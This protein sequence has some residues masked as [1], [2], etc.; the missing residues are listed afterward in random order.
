MS[1]RTIEFTVSA[2]GSV[3]PVT[4]QKAGIQGEHNKTELVISVFR[5]ENLTTS[6]FLKDVI[7]IQFIDGAGGFYSTEILNKDEEGNVRCTIPDEVTNAGGLVCAYVVLTQL[8]DTGSG[9]VRVKNVSISKPCKLRFEHSGVGSPSEYAYRVNISGALLNAQQ[10]AEAAENYADNSLNY[11]NLAKDYSNAAKTAQSNAEAAANQASSNA[12][13]AEAKANEATTAK[14]NAERSA[15]IAGA[16]EENANKH[17]MAVK[18]AV[19]AEQKRIDNISANAIKGTVSGSEILLTDVSPIVHDMKVRVSSDSIS[20][21]STVKLIKS[22]GSGETIAEY[23]PTADGTVD[24]VTSRGAKQKNKSDIW[25]GSVSTGLQGT[26]SKDDPFLINSAADFAYFATSSHAKQYTKLMSDIY[27]NDVSDPEWYKGENLNTWT[28]GKAPGNFDGNGYVV[29]GIYINEPDSEGAGLFGNIADIAPQTISNL[30]IE[31]S[32]ISVSTSSGYATALFYMANWGA[33]LLV[34]NCYVSDTVILKGYNAGGLAGYLGVTTTFIN[35]YAS[36]KIIANYLAGALVSFGSYHD[37]Y[38]QCYSSQN[39]PFVRYGANNST[40]TNCYAVNNT[41]CSNVSRL[42][43]EQMTGKAAYDNMAGLDFRTVWYVNEYGLPRLRAF[44][45][46]AIE[47]TTDTEGVKIYC[48]YNKNTN[49]CLENTFN[50]IA[51][52]KNYADSTFA[53][54]AALKTLKSIVDGKKVTYRDVAQNQKLII[55]KSKVYIFKAYSIDNAKINLWVTDSSGTEAQAYDD[56]D[57]LFPNCTAGILICPADTYNYS[58]V[59]LVGIT[60]KLSITNL[61]PFYGKGLANWRHSSI[62]NL[63]LKL[64]AGNGMGVW[65]IA[66]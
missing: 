53:T 21:L 57:E 2:D 60:G 32:Y 36:A 39:L 31:D 6:I 23:T 59:L 17:R 65:T 24:S 28:P 64:T 43:T 61:S 22:N 14:E 47:L 4:E 45:Y 10:S 25:D 18:E 1:L 19:A 55:E 16:H 29:H 20:D 51:S 13:A 46:D 7:R 62:K 63:F 8:Y 12:E 66:L 3:T 9:P 50:K 33:S 56:N 58:G 27:L 49:K 5:F 11:S 48:E 35:C 52:L 15:S 44:L 30:G 34:K 41:Y 42:T 54:T 26:G 38:N 37:V 40:F